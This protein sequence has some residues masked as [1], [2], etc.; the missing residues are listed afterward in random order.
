MREKLKS[1][2]AAIS[3]LDTAVSDTYTSWSDR[4]SAL[5][6]E[7]SAVADEISLQQQAYEKYMDLANSVGLDEYYQDLIKNGAID[8]ITVDDENLQDQIDKF[9]DFYDKAQDCNDKI[10]DL[11]QNLKELQKTKFDNIDFAV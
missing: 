10:K 4:N 9:Q 6:N 2:K 3:N 1:W 5:S 7:L 8:V 11:N